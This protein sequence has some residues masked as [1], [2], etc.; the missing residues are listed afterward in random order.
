MSAKQIRLPLNLEP[1]DDHYARILAELI[2]EEDPTTNWDYAYQVASNS[3]ES[4][5]RY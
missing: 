4:D 3:I 2:I 5:G 1:C